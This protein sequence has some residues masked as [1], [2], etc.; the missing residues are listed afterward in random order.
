M[1]TSTSRWRTLYSGASVENYARPHGVS[2]D[3]RP[4]AGGHLP[5]RIHARYRALFGLAGARL[6]QW[7]IDE[8]IA[9]LAPPIDAGVTNPDWVLPQF[10]L[11][12]ANYR[13]PA[14]RSR[15]PQ[16]TTS[17]CWPMRVLTEWQTAAL[18]SRRR[19]RPARR[20]ARPPSP[21]HHSRKSPGRRWQVGRGAPARMKPSA[22]RIR[23]TLT[24]HTGSHTWISRAVTPS[25]RCPPDCA[26]GRR[27]QDRPESRPGERAAVYRRAHDLA[28]RREEA[29]KAYQKVIDDFE[30]QNAA[31]AARIGLI[32]P[33]RSP[34]K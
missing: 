11:R 5:G 12:R 6:S 21:R 9:A 24:S 14:Q 31:E 29:R 2:A 30:K 19:S 32:T 28:G 1:T 10:L 7:R 25:A 20:R 3:H 26:G 16:T 15:P 8:A 34:V 18:I 4:P 22:R 23:R 33:Y 27:R 13:A 17:G